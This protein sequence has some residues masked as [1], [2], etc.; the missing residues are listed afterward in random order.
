MQR[1]LE[2]KITNQLEKKKNRL[3]TFNSNEATGKYIFCHFQWLPKHNYDIIFTAS[4][5]INLCYFNIMILKVIFF[6]IL[7]YGCGFYTLFL[8][9]FLFKLYVSICM[10]I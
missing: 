10:F 5:F 7:S 4:K 9:I 1:Y 8:K 2:N 3:R 6:L